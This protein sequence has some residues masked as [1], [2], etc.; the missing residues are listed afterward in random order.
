MAKPL[1][2]RLGID[3]SADPAAIRRAY[4]KMALKHHPDKNPG[5][6]TATA[7]F[8]Q[9]NA[10]FAILDNVEKKQA[11]DEGLIDE[12]GLAVQREPS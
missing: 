10:A 12:Q 3:E 11:Y 4:R 5:D 8:Q 2:Q 9:I 6:S 1:Y 7:T